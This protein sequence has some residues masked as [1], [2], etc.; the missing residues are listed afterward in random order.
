MKLLHDNLQPVWPAVRRRAF[1][2]IEI[3]VAVALLSFI[4]VGLLAMFY[5]VQRTFRAGTAQVD[6][7]EGG[8]ASMSLLVRDLQ[9]MTASNFELVTNC[10]VTASAGAAECYQDLPTG[11]RRTNFFQD[12]SFI[13]RVNDE[14]TGTSYR[15][16]NVVNGVGVLYRFT[17]NRFRETTPQAN[18]N[19]MVG[20][21]DEVTHYT[22]LGNPGFKKVLDG[23]VSLRVQ[24][25]FTNGIA[26]FYNDPALALVP[27]TTGTDSF[28]NRYTNANLH[29][30]LPDFFMFRSNALPA[31]VDIELAVLEPS[32]L[33]KFRVREESGQV[34]ALEYLSRQA[35][36]THVFRQRVAIRPATTD[37]RSLIL[38]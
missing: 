22:Q 25:V 23:V 26:F 3:M 13:A 14:W 15:I 35:G 30:V 7:M 31:Y 19:S 36:R 17:T 21:S 28:G 6:V 1:S 4:I 8:R 24:P 5:Q 34:Q 20:L 29:V 37:L 12:I 11:S 9:E 10:L 16:S 32:T 2:L 18:Y 27:N 33:T 38:N